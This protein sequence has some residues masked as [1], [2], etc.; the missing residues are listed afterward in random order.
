MLGEYLIWLWVLN[1][2]NTEKQVLPRAV[3]CYRLY[4]DFT[5]S[6]AVLVKT[7]V[8]KSVVLG[9]FLVRIKHHR[10]IRR[11]FMGIR[12]SIAVWHFTADLVIRRA[13]QASQ[14]TPVRFFMTCMLEASLTL[15]TLNE[16]FISPATSH[17][18][19]GWE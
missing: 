15:H 2:N 14:N 10:V 18:T 19:L 12:N 11:L 5:R 17:N 3:Y 6:S 4:M 9:F 7:D 8:V 1:C 16:D 13:K